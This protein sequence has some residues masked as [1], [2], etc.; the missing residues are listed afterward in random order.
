MMKCLEEGDTF[1]YGTEK[2]D[3]GTIAEAEKHDEDKRC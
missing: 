2:T 3:H 1:G